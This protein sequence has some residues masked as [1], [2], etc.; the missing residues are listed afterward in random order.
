M[1]L[2]CGRAPFWKIVLSF[3]VAVG[4]LVAGA[5][6]QDPAPPENKK[7][8]IVTRIVEPFVM[9]RNGELQ[10]YSIDL[11]RRVAEKA[12]LTYEFSV[13]KTVPDMLAALRDDSADVGV[14]ALTINAE[15]A[16]TIGFSHPFYQSGLKIAV[17]QSGNTDFLAV[18]AAFVSKDFLMVLL[19]VLGLLMISALLV[20][21]LEYKTN[22][23][24][25][26]SFGEAIWY[27]LNIIIAGGCE[28]K[29]PTS[30]GGRIVATAWML[31]S[32]VLVASFTATITSTMTVSNLSSDIRSVNDLVGRT[33]GTLQGTSADHFLKSKGVEPKYY[34]DL[35]AA[36]AALQKRELQAVVYDAPMLLYLTK[37]MGSS[38]QLLPVL[39]ER[40]AYGI[41][42]SEASSQ[43]RKPINVALLSLGE[44]G[45]LDELDKK[46]FGSGE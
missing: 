42:I 4:M 3:A 22:D 25:F 39:L 37:D 36:L 7:L 35:R 28:N 31:I 6:A 43:L 41:G 9:E 17:A 18:L 27:S 29:S 8:K 24:S 16:K 10:G 13:V 26:G 19:V 14:A 32:L 45:F 44:E 5:L 46:W 23:E 12:D 21:L 15:R 20:W 11:W 33:V 38:V 40:Q 1:I 30:L 2:S 34:P